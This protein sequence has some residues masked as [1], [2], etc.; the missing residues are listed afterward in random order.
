MNIALQLRYNIGMQIYMLVVNYTLE[1]AAVWL[2]YCSYT[3]CTHYVFLYYNEQ[4]A[5]IK[6]N[7]SH[8]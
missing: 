3:G 6:F 5:I 4:I 8:E 7:V 1:P 2:R